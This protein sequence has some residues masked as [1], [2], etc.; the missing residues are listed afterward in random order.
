MP[1]TRR[2][3]DKDRDGRERWEGRSSFTSVHVSYL[4]HQCSD[5]TAEKSHSN[6]YFTC[7]YVP[8]LYN[9][10]WDSI[11]WSG[12][13]NLQGGSCCFPTLCRTKKK[14]KED[15]FQCSP[16]QQLWPSQRPSAPNISLFHNWKRA[17]AKRTVIKPLSNTL[18]ELPTIF[19]ARCFW[20]SLSFYWGFF[21]KQSLDSNPL[22]FPRV[23][24]K[25]QCS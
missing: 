13:W 8:S 14:R 9:P 7:M 6:F 22:C 21:L 1:L 10:R 19:V 23:S 25:F 5:A 2:K 17:R 24:S 3:R 20:I 4:W 12:E 18:L 16:F 11:V 15:V